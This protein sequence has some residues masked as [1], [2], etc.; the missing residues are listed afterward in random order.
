M[1]RTV[2]AAAKH[3]ALAMLDRAELCSKP[4][5]FHELATV[6]EEFG[7]TITA[8]QGGVRGTF[9]QMKKVEE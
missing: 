1:I 2:N 9:I 7:Y 4:E 6:L 5:F 8:E 3:I